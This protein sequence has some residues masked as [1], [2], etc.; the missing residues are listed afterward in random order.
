MCFRWWQN[1]SRNNL[2][3]CQLLKRDERDLVAMRNLHADVEKQFVSFNDIVPY[4]HNLR[5]IYSP[6]LYSILQAASAQIIGMMHILYNQY[7]P[8]EKRQNEF[9]FYFKALNKNQL[10]TIQKISPKE[11]YDSILQPFQITGHEKT[12]RWWQEYNDTKHDLPT[13]AY[14]A[15]MKNVLHALGA[16]AILHDFGDLLMRHADPKKLF[17]NTR[18]QDI[19]IEFMTDYKRLENTNLSDGIL[20]SANRGFARYKSD[21]F[22]YL[23]EY[24][25]S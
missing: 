23:T 8:R 1:L 20:H 19:S 22:F 3:T 13:G 9:P 7:N 15:K 21:L 10:L 6:K 16:L 24:H 17:D 14:R 2:E 5:N 12:P 18:W 4:R 25:L 11:Q